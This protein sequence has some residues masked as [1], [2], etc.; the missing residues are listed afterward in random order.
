MHDSNST[1]NV[2]AEEVEKFNDMAH[3]WW[4]PNGDF[5]PLHDINPARVDYICERAPILAPGRCWMLAAAA[6]F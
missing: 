3:R 4:D 1:I 5:K 6:A 2:D